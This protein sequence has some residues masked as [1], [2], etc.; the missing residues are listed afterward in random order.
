VRRDGSIDWACLSRFDDGGIFCGLLDEERGGR[1]ALVARELRS[2]K[3][4]YVPD[5]NVLETT[6]VTATGEARLFDCFTLRSGGGRRPYRQLLRVVEGVRGEVT[7]D[8]ELAPRFDYAGLHPWL[9]HHRR[10]RVFS[11][12][13]GDD[14]FVVSTDAH[15]SIDPHAVALRGE[16]SVRAQQRRRLSLMGHRPHELQLTHL[17]ARTLDRRL[18]FTIDWW[19]H[20]VARGQYSDE[21]RESVVR[22][23]LVLKLLTCAPTGA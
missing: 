1:F 6:F 7:F 4:R 13:G 21:Y 22:S 15:L 18:Q 16:L 5:T 12:V 20:W 9:T 23:A 8:V 17:S 14:A 10:E 2:V 3:R 19:R 11:A